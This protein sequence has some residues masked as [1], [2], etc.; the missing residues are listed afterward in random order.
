MSQR[1]RFDITTNAS[2]DFVD[3]GPPITGFVTMLRFSGAN[4]DTG[5]SIKLEGVQSG[6]IVADYDNVGGQTFTRV[7]RIATYDTGGT[8][9]GDAYA[10]F[11]HE[12]LRLTVNQGANDTGNKTGTFY[13]WATD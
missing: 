11:H 7:P 13:G 1:F 5:C 10:Y 9:I 8:E 6:V 2:G 3:T 12:R 4:F